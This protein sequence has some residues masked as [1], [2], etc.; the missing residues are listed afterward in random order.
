MLAVALAITMIPTSGALADTLEENGEEVE[1]EGFSQVVETPIE[2]ELPGDLEF[3]IN[4]LKVDSDP[5]TAGLQNAQIISTD[6]L[7]ENHGATDVIV[8]VNAKVEG[9]GQNSKVQIVTEPATTLDDMGELKSSADKKAVNMVMLLPT[10]INYNSTDDEFSLVTTPYGVAKDGT[11]TLAGIT[12]DSAYAATTGAILFK[13]GAY[14]EATDKLTEANVSGFKFD[15]LVD[16]NKIYEEEDVK[17]TALFK[18]KAI[19]TGQTEGLD[20]YETP[21]ATGGFHSSVVKA[22]SGKEELIP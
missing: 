17:V 4:P 1:I 18:V 3:G 12:L 22:Q 8:S 6:F 10:A 15:G 13:L 19:T 21:D 20:P 9:N 5:D 2:I 11:T 16:P 7:V 14:D